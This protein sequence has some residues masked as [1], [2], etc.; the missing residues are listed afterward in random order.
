M[1]QYYGNQIVFQDIKDKSDILSL[2]YDFCVQHKIVQENI[3]FLKTIL[4]NEL[5]W[6]WLQVPDEWKEDFLTQWK[7]LLHKIKLKIWSEHTPIQSLFSYIY[8]GDFYQATNLLDAFA[9]EKKRERR[10][11]MP[12]LI[13]HPV[14]LEKCAL[15]FNCDESFIPF[16]SVT[17]ASIQAHSK[18]QCVY[19]I[20]I[21]NHNISRQS[22]RVIANMFKGQKNFNIRFYDMKEYVTKYHIDSWMSL[23][24][25]K[26][27]AYYRLFIPI[28]FSNFKRV[29]YLDCDLIVN[30]DISEL[31]H[32]P[33]HNK[34]LGAVKDLFVS[35]VNSTNDFLFPGFYQY[36]IQT[37]KLP[38]LDE[39]V[40][41]GVLVLDIPK[42]NTNKYEHNILE[43]VQ[44]NTAYFH[45][46]NIWNMLFYS[47]VCLLDETWNV[48]INNG[49]ILGKVTYP[50]P[51]S[52][53]ILHFCSKFKPWNTLHWKQNEISLRWWIYARLSPFYEK[54]LFDT[55]CR[56]HSPSYKSP[57]KDILNFP[58]VYWTYLR[59]RIWSNFT[60]GEKRQHYLYK[61]HVFHNEVRRIRKLLK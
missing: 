52:I 22:Q 2:L 38:H 50:K 51:E 5:F 31:Y 7:L 4:Y 32:I 27:S 37:M 15:V 21:L 60:W 13:L 9:F 44:K 42:I 19:D 17:L 59:C 16:L 25:I 41:S 34:P 6:A 40:N 14:F 23:R 43:A 54:I 48:Q 28:I 18:P 47:K 29:I 12:N 8:N 30:T 3:V 53:K 24:N 61:K 49:N 57:L 45:D 39:Y 1:H 46:Q 55:I 11:S 35:K 20:V 26:P 58:K 36:A 56:E 10:K 33:L